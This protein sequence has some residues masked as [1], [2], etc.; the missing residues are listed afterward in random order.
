[1]KWFDNQSPST[2]TTCHPS[3]IVNLSNFMSGKSIV[4]NIYDSFITKKTWLIPKVADNKVHSMNFLE[5]G[6]IHNLR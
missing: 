6:L 2:W 1:M 4:G 3:N 5:D